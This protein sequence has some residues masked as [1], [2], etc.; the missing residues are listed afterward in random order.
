L[1]TVVT[2]ALFLLAIL[3][4]VAYLTVT[5]KDASATVVRA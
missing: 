4:A 2:S 1:G 5:K 3:A